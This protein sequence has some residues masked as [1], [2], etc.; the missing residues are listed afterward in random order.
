MAQEHDGH[1]EKIRTY[2]KMVHE[3]S[4]DPMELD[5]SSIETRLDQTVRELQRR[6]EEQQ[7]ALESV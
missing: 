4:D 5:A 3:L 6:V 1:L 2:S 7:A